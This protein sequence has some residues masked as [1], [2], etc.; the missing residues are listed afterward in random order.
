MEHRDSRPR[1]C[2]LVSMALLLAPSIC[3]GL[4]ATGGPYVLQLRTDECQLLVVGSV[5]GTKEFD[6]DKAQRESLIEVRRVLYGDAAAGDTLSVTW[7]TGRWVRK[8]GGGSGISPRGPQLSSLPG[9]HVWLI[10]ERQGELGCVGDPIPLGPSARSTMREYLDWAQVPRMPYGGLA[11]KDPAI[12]R[13]DGLDP[14][15]GDAVRRVLAAYLAGYLD[16]QPP[17]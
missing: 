17:E 5:V 15:R 8:D 6:P 1:L 4:E 16:G 2:G 11:G 13:A 10:S 14:E 3:L 7:S 9:L 12:A